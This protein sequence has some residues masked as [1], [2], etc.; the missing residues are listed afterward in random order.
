MERER[1]VIP[2]ERRQINEGKKIADTE[3]RLFVPQTKQQLQKKPREEASSVCRCVKYRNRRLKAKRNSSG[4]SLQTDNRKKNG[5]YEE[6][7]RL[8]ERPR[9]RR[10]R[11]NENDQERS[12]TTRQESEK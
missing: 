5:E 4:T 12:R 11:R 7:E 3:Y 6:E 9:E 1:N 2:F 10:R 8:R